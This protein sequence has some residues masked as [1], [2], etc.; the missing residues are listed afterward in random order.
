[1]RKES[2]IIVFIMKI[3]NTIRRTSMFGDVVI[4]ENISAEEA[5]KSKDLMKEGFTFEV[6]KDSKWEEVKPLIIHQRAVP[7]SCEACSS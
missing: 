6:F 2:A 1:M 5:K 4:R 3:G 7:E